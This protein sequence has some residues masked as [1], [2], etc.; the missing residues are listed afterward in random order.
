MAKKKTNF[1]TEFKEFITKGNVIDLAVGVIIGAAFKDIVTSL[2]SDIIMP[3]IS[4]ATGRVNFSSW[5]IALDGKKYAT[6]AAAK[7]AGASTMNFGTFISAILHF[8]IM[9]LVIFCI[10]KAI[11]K[12]KQGVKKL[13]GAKDPAATT[14]KCPYCKSEIAI[15]A[16]R[17]P[18]CTS[19][20]EAEK[21][22]K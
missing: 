16:T 17:C 9:A 19:E 14:K 11:S 8:L 15:D 1:F 4:L 18:H 3:T 5:F 13:T 12:A 6:L 22:N 2:V 21:E 20:L 7:E 10:I